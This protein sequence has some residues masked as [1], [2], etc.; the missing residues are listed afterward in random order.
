[1]ELELPGMVKDQIT[2]EVAEGE[3]DVHGEVKQREHTGAVRRHTRRVGQF[4]YRTTLPPTSGIEHIS[5]DLANGV[6]TVRDPKTEQGK[7]Q[8]IEITGWLRGGITGIGAR[9]RV[10]GGTS[11]VVGPVREVCGDRDH[12]VDALAQP[13]DDGDQALV[14]DGSADGDLPLAYLGCHFSGSKAQCPLQY[15]PGDLVAD[16]VVAAQEDPQQVAAADDALQLVRLVHDGQPL[17]VVDL[18]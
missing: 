13:L 16:G 1:V 11:G 15:V 10:G 3:F 7:A 5:A 4:D 9:S 6:L 18:Q 2:V 8:C 17:D 14:L 12:A